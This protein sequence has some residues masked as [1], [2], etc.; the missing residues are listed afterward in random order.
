M[1]AWFVAAKLAG[2]TMAA[3]TDAVLAAGNLGRSSNIYRTQHS[4]RRHSATTTLAFMRHAQCHCFL[5]FFACNLGLRGFLK[6]FFDSSLYTRHD[7]Q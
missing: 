4:Q 1:A 2:P 3:C 6:I 7:W 5:P